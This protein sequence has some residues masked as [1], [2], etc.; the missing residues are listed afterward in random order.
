MG[1]YSKINERKHKIHRDNVAAGLNLGKQLIR[2]TKALEDN[3]AKMCKHVDNCAA[4]VLE[5]SK[6]QPISPD[7][8]LHVTVARIERLGKE[9]F[10]APAR[11]MTKAQLR[12]HHR[13]LSAIMPLLKKNAAHAA[14]LADHLTQMCRFVGPLVALY[15]S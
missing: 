12:M 10:R 9:I 14:A 6:R 13:H 4:A 2:D 8:R 5:Q 11:D 1:K 3:W 7:P 15:K